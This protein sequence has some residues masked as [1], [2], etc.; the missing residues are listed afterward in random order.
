MEFLI[1]FLLGMAATEP[2]A[3]SKPVAP[4]VELGVVLVVI[5]FAV[6]CVWG[7]LRSVKRGL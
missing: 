3:P 2:S 7:L 5:A 6:A 4:E 1:G